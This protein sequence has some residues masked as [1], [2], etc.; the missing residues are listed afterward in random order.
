MQA[1][2]IVNTTK[3]DLA[4]I[5]TL[6]DDAIAYQK[7]KGFPVWNGYDKQVLQMLRTNYSSRLLTPI[8]HYLSSVSVMQI[9]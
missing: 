7:R 8:I 5:C 4:F 3:E 9:G 2:H 6:F 1:F